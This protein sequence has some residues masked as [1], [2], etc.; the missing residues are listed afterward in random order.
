MACTFYTVNATKVIRL[1][2]SL[3]IV[4]LHSMIGYWHHPVVHPSVCDAVHC[5]SQG[6]CIRL[7][8][9]PVCF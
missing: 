2:N 3:E 6:W 5:G 8:V 9:A 4:L 7:K 1:S